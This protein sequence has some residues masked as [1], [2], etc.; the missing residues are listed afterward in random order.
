MKAPN[1]RQLKKQ[2]EETKK[3]EQKERLAKRRPP[4]P[5]ESEPKTPS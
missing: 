5:A 4:Q 1:Y 2:R 3:R